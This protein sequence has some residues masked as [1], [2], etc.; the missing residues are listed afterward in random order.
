MITKLISI[1]NSRG[2]RIP[3]PL[4]DD[5]G[6]G[7]EVE[8]KVKKGRNKDRFRFSKKEFSNRD[9]PINREN[10]CYRLE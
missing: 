3:K 7:D 8:L 4:L 5:S 6:L 9:I 2:I 10:S 1:G